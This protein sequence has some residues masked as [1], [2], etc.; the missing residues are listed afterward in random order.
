MKHLIWILVVLM[1]LVSSAMAQ[2]ETARDWG[3]YTQLTNGA[4]IDVPIALTTDKSIS[5]FFTQAGFKNATKAGTEE[6]IKLMRNLWDIPQVANMRF[7]TWQIMLVKPKLVEW[8]DT[9][10]GQVDKAMTIWFE[11]AKGVKAAPVEKEKE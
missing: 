1:M 3:V 11:A 9:F 10:F 6:A 4:T 7:G 2:E 8:D 5:P